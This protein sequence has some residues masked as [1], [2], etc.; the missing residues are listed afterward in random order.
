VTDAPSLSDALG[1]RRGDVVALTGGGGKTTAVL[2]L[3]RELSA[4]GFRVIASTTT[5]VEASVGNA[6]PVV[7]SGTGVESRLTAALARGGAVFLAAGEAADGRLIG[8]APED[9]DAISALGL[10]D[11]TVVEADGSRQRPL[12][13]PAAHE[14]VV[15]SR[16]TI[17]SF[18]MGIDALGEPVDGPMVH[19]PELVRAF[20]APSVTV[21]LMASLAASPRAGLKGAPAAAA[22]RPIVNKADVARRADAEAVAAAVLAFGPPQ[23]DR[24]LVTDIATSSF[25][26]VTRRG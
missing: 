21:E 2:R 5:H 1:V 11:V 8:V 26:V 7:R 10:A 20:G 9:V 17:V 13:A 23:I 25:A 12:K 14:P 6:L 3:S 19:R 15:P 16:A 22:A 4:E 24:A 18:V